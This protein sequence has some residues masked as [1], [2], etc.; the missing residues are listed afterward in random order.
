MKNPISN[1]NPISILMA[2]RI[3]QLIFLSSMESMHTEA[4]ILTLGLELTATE[5]RL[6][7]A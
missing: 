1:P 2:K 7:N 4:V 6:K 3:Q 5:D